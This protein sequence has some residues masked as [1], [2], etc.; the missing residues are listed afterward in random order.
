DVVTMAKG[1]GNGVT[2]G[3]GWA[4]AK[5]AGVF[6]PGDHSTT[7]GGHPLAA[8][9]ARAMLA[10]MEA[11][12][13]PTRE[14]A[15][16]ERFTALLGSLAE[17]SAVRGVGLLLAVELDPDHLPDGGAAELARRLL[18]RGVV[19]N[20]VTPTA[21]RLAPSLRISDDELDHGVQVITEVL[22]AVTSD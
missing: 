4:R 20:P 2:I 14:S 22:A 10:V 8:A 9:A 1:L 17:V 15:A 12:D 3:A 16:G 7:Y 19:V 6:E 13:V 21:L 5:V 18:D 11:E